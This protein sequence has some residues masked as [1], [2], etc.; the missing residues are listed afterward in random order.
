M[1]FHNRTYQY[2]R[3]KC[4]VCRWKSYKPG[5]LWCYYLATLDQLSQGET[6]ED[7][8][9]TIGLQ[10]LRYSEGS[11]T[12][13][14]FDLTDSGGKTVTNIYSND[15]INFLPYSEFMQYAKIQ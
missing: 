15:Q 9:D 6:F 7:V 1:K 5:H 13:H 11:L 12:E 2:E 10:S 14:Y 3:F 8:A 4:P